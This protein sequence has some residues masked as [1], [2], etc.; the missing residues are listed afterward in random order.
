[1][2]HLTLELSIQSLQFHSCTALSG[3][4]YK[5]G[6]LH[7]VPLVDLVFFLHIEDM[8]ERLNPLSGNRK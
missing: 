8:I 1:M 2:N 6:R 7:L 3:D 4:I 5:L